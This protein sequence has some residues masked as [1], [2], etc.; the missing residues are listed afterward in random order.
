MCL[1]CQVASFKPTGVV[2]A[3][4][5][6]CAASPPY[7]ACQQHL[8][9]SSGTSCGI[10]IA[11]RHLSTSSLVALQH[12][13]I[14]IATTKGGAPLPFQGPPGGAGAAGRRRRGRH[15]GAA[16]RRARRGACA[17]AIAQPKILNCPAS[18]S[19]CCSVFV[20]AG[21]LRV[22]TRGSDPSDSAAERRHRTLRIQ[23][24]SNNKRGCTVSRMRR[25]S[26]GRTSD[27]RSSVFF[28]S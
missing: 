1:L 27:V 5:K 19:G 14:A 16:L 26:P 2:Y 9:T 13:I 28:P 6:V 12:L 15:G 25:C 24:R 22:P 7:H 21:P 23:P 20:Q 11:M 4:A 17:G 3:L 10:I 8:I 18:P